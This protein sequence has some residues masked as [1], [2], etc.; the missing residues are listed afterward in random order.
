M[1]AGELLKNLHYINVRIEVKKQHLKD[2]WEEATASG[3]I[4]YDKDRVVTSL[5]QEG[6]FENKAIN[7]AM[8]CEEIQKDL[9]KLTKQY[10]MGRTIIN[11]IKNP[12]DRAIV[13]LI[14]VENLK[15]KDV[16]L[17]LHYTESNVYYRK[18]RIMA[19]LNNIVVNLNE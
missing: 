10:E 4:R 11:G 8:L 14:Y 19:K 5:R 17:K 6:G 7:Y 18:K 16:A 12:T 15:I 13:D 2:L 9:D 3:G 1:T